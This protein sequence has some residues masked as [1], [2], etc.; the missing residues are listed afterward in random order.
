MLWELPLSRRN[1]PLDEGINVI[2]RT[3]QPEA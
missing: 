3:R 1:P 2:T